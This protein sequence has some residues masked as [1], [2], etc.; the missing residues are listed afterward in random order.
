MQQ[1]REALKRVVAG[2]PLREIA[3]RGRSFDDL[4]AQGA[5]CCRGL[6]DPGLKFWV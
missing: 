4:A 6:S 1:A 5:P 3:L 2:E